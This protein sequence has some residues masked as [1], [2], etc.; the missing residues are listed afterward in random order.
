MATKIR[1]LTSQILSAQRLAA[2]ISVVVIVATAASACLSE[3]QEPSTAPPYQ[4]I[5]SIQDIMLSLVDPA[6]DAI[7]ESVAT[8]MTF[9]NIEERRPSTEEEWQ[10]L[11]REGVRLVEA[12]NLLLIPGRD[13]A[14]PGFQSEYPGI[15]LEPDEIM[16]L[17]DEDRATW[18]RLLGNYYQASLSMLR[19]IEERD[20]DRMFDEG[21]PLDVTC[22]QCHLTYWYPNQFIPPISTV[23]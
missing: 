15:E 1:T 17:I 4:P 20:V 16:V 23:E 12:T 10:A 5:T 2:Q 6:A 14:R 7:W 18:N 3:S 11:H 22:E 21:G 8:I 19:A 13:A 9:G